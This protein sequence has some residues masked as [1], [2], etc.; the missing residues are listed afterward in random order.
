[1]LENCSNPRHLP[2][3]HMVPSNVKLNV[4][5]PLCVALD[6]LEALKNLLQRLDDIGDQIDTFFNE[7]P[8]E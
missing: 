4:R 8:R 7:F 3:A 2:I 1:M 6:K 5:C